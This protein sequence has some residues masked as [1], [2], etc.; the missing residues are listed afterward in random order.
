MDDECDQTGMAS[1]ACET[2]GFLGS[3]SWSQS[4]LSV[5]EIA[6]L[7]TGARREQEG[8]TPHWVFRLPSASRV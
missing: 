6:I 5:T 4:A 2:R 8:L 7:S 1:Y 3:G